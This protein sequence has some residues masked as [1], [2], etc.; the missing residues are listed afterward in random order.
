MLPNMVITLTGFLKETIFVRFP[1][2]APYVLIIIIN[3]GNN[4]NNNNGNAY[5]YNKIKT[6]TN[7]G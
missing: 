6:I 1:Q 3:N 4:N 7:P 2:F 5:N